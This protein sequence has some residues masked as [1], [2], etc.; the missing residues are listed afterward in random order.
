MPPVVYVV[1]TNIDRELEAEFDRWYD[2]EHVPQHFEHPGIVRAR[3]FRF[4]D[5]EDEFDRVE[6]YRFLALYEYESEAAYRDYVASDLRRRLVADHRSRFGEPQS[7]L[8][9]AVQLSE[10]PPP[11]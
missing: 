1:R 2:E 8:E 7:A 3:R 4:L 11:R 10:W 5:R 9:V 6:R